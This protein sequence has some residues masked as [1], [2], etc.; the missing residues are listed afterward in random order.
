MAYDPFADADG[1]VRSLTPLPP[2]T[3]A[4]G[5]PEL[6]Q[7]HSSIL[8]PSV[9]GGTDTAGTP[10]DSVGS[11]E[12]G[13]LA[14]EGAALAG[15]GAGPGVHSKAMTEGSAGG[16]GTAGA[17]ATEAARRRRRRR[18]LFL[19]AAA[20][21]VVAIA[22]AVPIG[23]VFGRKNS[24]GSG[25]GSGGSGGGSG[26][27]KNGPTTGGDGSTVTTEDGSTFIYSN[28]FGGIWVDDPD[29]PF[30]GAAFPND[31]TP[32]LNTSW[33]WGVDRLYGVNL[34]GWFVLEP[35][36]IPSLFEKYQNNFTAIAANG[37]QPVVVDEWTLSQAMA[38]DTSAGGGL[39][40]LEDHYNTYGICPLPVLFFTDFLK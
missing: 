1:G 25:G 11:A 40:Q 23:V 18:W 16:V 29:D 37:G 39:S 27:G 33:T 14:A 34:G 31:F 26:G 19:G 35:F 28:Q 6:V 4:G 7:R 15:T 38:A 30:S 10:R 8:P 32:P 3:R 22:V 36:I 2:D 12:G 13:P 9:L 21:L 17:A 5:A 20:L 24:S